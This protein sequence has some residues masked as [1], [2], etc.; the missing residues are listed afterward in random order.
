MSYLTSFGLL[1]VLTGLVSA[2]AGYFAAQ[3]SGVLI[4]YGVATVVCGIVLWLVGRRYR[5]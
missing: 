3:N 2:A 4:G 5:N 1:L